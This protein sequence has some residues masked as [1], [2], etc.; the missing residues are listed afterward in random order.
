MRPVELSRRPSA[1]SLALAMR[2]NTSDSSGNSFIDEGR[3]AS[4]GGAA[5]NSRLA[6]V[7]VAASQR[8]NRAERG[9]FSANMASTPVLESWGDDGRKSFAAGFSGDRLSAVQVEFDVGRQ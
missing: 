7:T 9:I 8:E 2:I 6:N 3:S 4:A 5:A 1:N